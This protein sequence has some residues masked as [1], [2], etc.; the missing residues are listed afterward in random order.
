MKAILETMKNISVV[1][2]LVTIKSTL[3]EEN[4]ADLEALAD[5]IVDAGV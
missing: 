5:A 1:E 3:K 2:P 4:M